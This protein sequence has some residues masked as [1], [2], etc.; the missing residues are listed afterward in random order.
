MSR[1]SMTT[2]VSAVVLLVLV[3]PGPATAQVT[4]VCGDVSGSWAAGVYRSTCSLR[5]PVGQS[6]SLGNIYDTTSTA[7]DVAFTYRDDA[8]NDFFPFGTGARS[9]YSPLPTS[10]P[11]ATQRVPE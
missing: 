6:L 10:R 5:V 11:C 3:V 9:E 7:M 4:D 1:T 8:T 2:A